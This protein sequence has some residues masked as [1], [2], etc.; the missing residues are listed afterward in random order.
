V[1]FEEHRSRLFSLAYRMLGSA[2]DAEDVVQASWER[3]CVAQDVRDEAALLTTIVTRLCLDELRSARRRRET[4]VGPWLPEPVTS[5]DLGPLETV[6]Q[7]E[8]V[9]LGAMLL[10]ERLSPAE[11]AVCVLR[12]AFDYDYAGIA[13]VLER[14]EAGCRQLHRRARQRLAVGTARFEVT[15]DEHL[16]LTERLFTA[17]ALG[18]VGGL[19]ALLA[20][21]VE[22]I[23]DGGGKV[24]AAR[25]P[26][27]GARKAAAFL[28]GV[29]RKLEPGYEVLAT[30]LN[31]VPSLL[32]LRDG[33][34]TSVAQVVPSAAGVQQ[35]LI[36]MAPDK[37][38]RLS[39]PGALPRQQG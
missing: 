33:A 31:G 10:L 13:A 14:T 16:A 5:D 20:A 4:S 38:A 18:D 28:V 34:V 37:L 8:S 22:V 39:R 29:A 25:R 32:V 27:L 26:V 19:E 11:R 30:D 2:A 36:V 17:A 12:D 9:S 15:P 23:S 35:L 1:A 24:S 21:D 6:A 3:F 7:R